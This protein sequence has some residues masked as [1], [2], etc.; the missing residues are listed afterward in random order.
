MQRVNFD[1]RR[2]GP[3]PSLLGAGAAERRNKEGWGRA[4]RGAVRKERVKMKERSKQET[5]NGDER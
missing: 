5:K 4:E 1:L 2:S 3:S